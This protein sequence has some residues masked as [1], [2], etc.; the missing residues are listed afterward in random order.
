MFGYTA[1]KKSVQCCSIRPTYHD[2]ITIIVLCN[3]DNGLIG[4]PG[5][6]Y[7]VNGSTR[8]CCFALSGLHIIGNGLIRGFWIH[9]LVPHD[10]KD[11]ERILEP[12]RVLYSII[13][14]FLTGRPA[15]VG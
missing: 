8:H 7:R 15:V 14:S 11:I 4:L 6:D 9:L 2:R 5:L 10:R 3:L 13:Q 1:Q 12:D